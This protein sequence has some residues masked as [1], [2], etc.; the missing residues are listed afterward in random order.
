MSEF[1]KTPLTFGAI[2]IFSQ[3]IVKLCASLLTTS[4]LPKDQIFPALMLSTKVDVKDVQNHPVDDENRIADQADAGIDI[5]VYTL[6]LM[7]RF[8]QSINASLL[9]DEEKHMFDCVK[10]FTEGSC[11]VPEEPSFIHPERAT[12]LVGMIFSEIDELFQTLN[13]EQ[14]LLLKETFV[15][16]VMNVDTYSNYDATIENQSLVLQMIV[17]TVNTFFRDNADML[18]SVPFDEVHNANMRKRDPAT[19]KFIIRASDKKIMKPDGWVGPDILRSISD[20][21]NQI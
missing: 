1:F 11:E 3:K 15:A 5:I 7:C 20:Y 9:S 16:S 8:K 19:G 18:L 2:V 6:N 17:V 12:W 13:E 4:G 14:Y 10:E 21:R